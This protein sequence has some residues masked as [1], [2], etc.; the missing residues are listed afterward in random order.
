MQLCI[1]IVKVMVR[2]EMDSSILISYASSNIPQLFSYTIYSIYFFNLR[3]WFFF[4]LSCS[5]LFIIFIYCF[6]IFLL[7][8]RKCSPYYFPLPFPPL[9]SNLNCK[10]F[11]Q[12][13][14]ENAFCYNLS[15][16]VFID[17]ILIKPDYLKSWCNCATAARNLFCMF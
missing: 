13:L 12:D 11:L 7:I 3:V 6:H 14:I 8:V 17:Y 15:L 9:F 2:N 10:T 4:R 16:Q 5:L 1:N